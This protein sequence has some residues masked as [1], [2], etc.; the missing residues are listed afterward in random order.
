[1]AERDVANVQAVGSIPI[2]CSS[3][4][5]GCV[6]R[7]TPED[8]KLERLGHLW[9]GVPAEVGRQVSDVSTGLI[10]SDELRDILVLVMQDGQL[11]VASRARTVK[12]L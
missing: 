1:M 8:L 2:T 3:S 12:D 4:V 9:K 10:L 6:G 7:F 11:V 5:A